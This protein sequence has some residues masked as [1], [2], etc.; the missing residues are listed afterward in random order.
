MPGMTR[1]SYQ[2]VD[3]LKVKTRPI[4]GRSTKVAVESF[5]R[6]YEK[7]SGVPV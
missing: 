6:V 5:A 3:G 1:Y 7:G 2:P 4:R